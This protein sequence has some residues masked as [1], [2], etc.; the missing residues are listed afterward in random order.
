MSNFRHGHCC[1]G[2][3]SHTY[4]AW[5]AM[6][7]RCVTPTHKRYKDY[8][9]RG[10]KVC[11]RWQ[12]FDNFLADMG[13]KPKGM[14]IERRNNDA[15]YGP[16]NCYWATRTEQNRNKRTIKLTMED[17]RAIRASTLNGVELAKIYHTTKSTISLI[18]SHKQWR[19]E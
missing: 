14:S 15:D 17:A 2:K 8:G 6:L 19:E 5:S 13:T 9:G 12:L 10:I 3:V 18:R 4:M 16:A 11:A 1:N 7:Q